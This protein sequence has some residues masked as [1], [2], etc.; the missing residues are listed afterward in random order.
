M[1]VGVL[2]RASNVRSNGVAFANRA[3]AG[4]LLGE[5][6][7]DSHACLD[8]PPGGL[9]VVGLARGGVAV[10]AEVAA[11]RHAPLDAL[12]VRK[13]GHPW[14]PEYAIGAVAPRCNPY[15]RSHDGLTELELAAA[16]E[17]AQSRAA[18]LDQRLHEAYAPVPVAGATCVL[19]DDGLATGATMTA[20]VHWARAAGAR[21]VVVAVPVGA[22]A[23]VTAMEQAA[24]EVV[25]L[26]T[27]SDFGAVGLWYRDFPQLSDA[28]VISLLR[29]R[30]QQDA[31]RWDEEIPLAGTFHAADLVM[32]P[33]PVGW[34]LFAHGSGSSR[35]SPRNVRV[36]G[37]L[38]EAGIA[39]MLFDLLTP[40]EERLRRDVFDVELLG[41]RLAEAT[42]WLVGR[43]E[44][45]GLPVGFFG[46]STGAAAALLAAA[47][48]PDMIDAV[49]SRGGRPDLAE[50]RLAD[51]LAPTLLVVGGA[52]ELVLELNRRAARRLRCLHELQ[53]VPGATHL[54]EEP[55]TLESV[56]A[57]ATRWFVR[58][59]AAAGQR[60]H[61]GQVPDHVPV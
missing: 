41:R 39:T 45:A 5:A 48:H 43:P 16:V 35:R 15:V 23:T 42:H 38:N 44:V 47:D 58:H 31:R 60:L 25:C 36:A 57:L 53:V 61:R 33:A 27:S 4:R 56:C 13:I 34:V 20:S 24:D 37:A 29:L 8:A 6:V 19:V 55:G 10:A 54:F 32:P 18:L 17:V 2:H 51:V 40:A 49:V 7:F 22:A 9:V 21:R 12:A 26:E 11:L 52:D 59:L 46:A 14:Q 3:E 50:A 30:R 1:G 28:E